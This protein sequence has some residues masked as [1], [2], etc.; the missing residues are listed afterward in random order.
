MGKDGWRALTTAPE[1]FSTSHCILT[2]FYTQ[3]W[4]PSSLC[5]PSARPLPQPRGKRPG[6][7][8]LL[9]AGAMRDEGRCTPS[10]KKNVLFV[11]ISRSGVL[12][13]PS[14]ARKTGRSEDRRARATTGKPRTTMET[15]APTVSFPH[16]QARERNPSPL[17]KQRC[18]LCL[19][20]SHPTPPKPVRSG[21]RGRRGGHTIPPCQ[22]DSRHR[23]PALPSPSVES[24]EREAETERSSRRRSS[25]I[26]RLPTPSPPGRPHGPLHLFFFIIF[27]SLCRW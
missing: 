14:L 19:P 9:Q 21:A 27:D 4:K 8:A 7:T 2:T 13:I 22:T 16:E 5:L 18:Q 26:S 23:H 3:T 25:K 12:F 24:T 1:H 10:S 20:H 6:P 15:M 17:P 11:W